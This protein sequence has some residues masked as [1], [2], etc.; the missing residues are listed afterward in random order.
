VPAAEY[1]AA[2]FRLTAD[3]EYL[4]A[5]AK[6]K[7]LP[8]LPPE[9]MEGSESVKLVKEGAFDELIEVK[10]IKGIVH[11]HSTY[12]DGLHSLSDMATFT[13]NAGFQYMVITEHSKSSAFARGLTVE[14]VHQ[15]W[16]EIDE[17]N[18]TLKP[19]VIFKGIESDI[20]G[21]GS[22]DYD[23]ETLKGFDV[24][25][26]SI[27][28]GMQMDIG[29]ATAR[30]IKA[31]ENPYTRILGHPTGRLL[32]AR[33]GYPIDHKKV[34]DACAANKVAIELNGN[35]QRLD[36]DSVH[37]RT[38]LDKGVL[39]SINP[40]A[41]SMDSIHNVRFGVYAGR[42]GGLPGSQCLTTKTLADFK[43]WLKSR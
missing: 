14:R 39:L 7:A 13:K 31:I 9:L 19:F 4:K 34:I 40:D 42:R 8:Q 24:I 41:H 20:L 30:L 25:V 10:D 35:P 12:S 37:L 36:M 17:L 29:R 33:A 3:A 18:V 21:D 11:C 38:A 16:K 15:Q 27:H 2:K 26:A 32:L 23:E 22:L 5:T 1:E 6:L 28:N 43:K